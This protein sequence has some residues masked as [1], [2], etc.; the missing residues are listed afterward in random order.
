VIVIVISRTKE[1][2]AMPKRPT[3]PPGGRAVVPKSD[4]EPFFVFSPQD[5]VE[6]I[7]TGTKTINGRECYLLNKLG[8]SIGM[9][10]G[11]QVVNAPDG[12][13]GVLPNHVRLM[14]LLTDLP[15]GSR[16]WIEAAGEQELQNRGQAMRLYRVI[17]YGIPDE[18][19][20]LGAEDA[21][22]KGEPDVEDNDDDEQGE[23]E[24]PF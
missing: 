15:I 14:Q 8:G 7:L 6:G 1:C 19:L 4:L 10:H 20:P 12:I 24:T 16:V 17:D 2:D 9:K 13:V 22:S 23:D 21:G 11:D 5:A 18:Q 3:P